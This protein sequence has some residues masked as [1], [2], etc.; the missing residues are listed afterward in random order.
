[1]KKGI[2][3]FFTVLI[4]L[5]M[6]MTGCQDGSETKSKNKTVITLDPTTVTVEVYGTARITATTKPADLELE[7]YS[8]DEEVAYVN[9]VGQVTGVSPGTATITAEAEDGTKATCEVTVT[10]ALSSDVTIVG[11][12][13]VH[14]PVKLGGAGGR[15]G[16]TPGVANADGSYTFDGT[17]SQYNGDGAQYY[18]P[19]PKASDTWSLD[20]YELFEITFKT[21]SGGTEAIVKKG[22]VNE[23][24]MP[25]PI[26]NNAQ[27][28]TF[29]SNVNNGVLTY[30]AVISDAG[31][32]VGFQRNQNV[33]GLSPATVRID[34]VVFSKAEEYTVT[35]DGG[36]A[37]LTIQPIKVIKGRKV[38]LPYKPKWEGHTFTGWYD[39]DTLFDPETLINKN[40][41]LTAKWTDGDP[42][43]VD[44]KLDLTF[45]KDNLPTN[46]ALTGGS[47]SYTIPAEYADTVYEDGKLT[48]T[49][50]G[51]NRQRA[52]IPLNSDQIYELMD[53]A[54]SGATF[55]IVGTV[56]RGDQGTLT[57]DQ[58]ATGELGFAAFRL[59]LADPTA[60]G[61]WNATE[62]GKQT[63]L[64]GNINAADDHMVEYRAFSSNKSTA[65]L[66]YF[67]IQAM[68]KDDKGSPDSTKEGFPKVIITVESITIE[69]GNTTQ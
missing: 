50:D 9:P 12:T 68:F 43:P 64:T 51:R 10:P 57:N 2:Y 69:G 17:S 41:T 65:T 27:Y 45:N 38:T 26:V 36:G 19:T 22:S 11:D 49:F 44:M 31:A 61:N 58:I 18:F 1:M 29:N 7:W 39:G 47:P 16:G 13:L 30:K 46:A 54:L 40:Y 59:H 28:I 53:P 20:D 63:P 66:G 37:T 25:Y 62:T 33:S 5:A 34:K 35:F 4:V 8:S 21:I 52:I 3:A 42:T 55:R 60:L 6:V 15:W 56:E 48:I 14:N 24:L 23:D 32:G 67:V